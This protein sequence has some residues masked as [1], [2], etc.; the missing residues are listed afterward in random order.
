MGL[1]SILFTAG[2]IGV[3]RITMILQLIKEEDILEVLEIYTPYVLDT[4]ITFEDVV[5]SLESFSE[6]VEHYTAQFPWIVAREHGQIAG[7]AYASPYRERSAYQWGC[8]LSIYLRSDYQ[9][10][11]LGRTLY[12]ALMDFLTIQGY[13]SA[14]GIITLPNDASI[15]LHNQLGF[16]MDGI[17]KQVG[18][19]HGKWHDTAIMSKELLTHTSTPKAPP[20]SIHE[21]PSDVIN[22]ILTKGPL[23]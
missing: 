11:D 21:L 6:R 15:A 9:G 23:H 17:Q 4:D 12:S 16:E 2:T 1:I 7:Y 10:M 14:Y 22:A 5:P 8:E 13:Y 19:K 3:E 18:F 20:K